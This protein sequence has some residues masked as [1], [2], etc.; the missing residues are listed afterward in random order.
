MRLFGEIRRQ[1]D[2]K[3]GWNGGTLA[4]ADRWFP[5][6]TCSDRGTVK[7][8]LGLRERTFACE[9]CGLEMDRDLNAAINLQQYVDPEWPDDAKTGRGADQ[10]TGPG[11]WL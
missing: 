10:K 6:P 11:R 3:T 9:H 4:V 8:E 7:P 2:Y 5:P 1:L